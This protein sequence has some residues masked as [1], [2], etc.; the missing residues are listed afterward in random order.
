M[1]VY[2]EKIQGQPC[3]MCGAPRPEWHH[4][5]PRSKFSKRNKKLQEHKDNAIPLCHHCHQGHHT[6]HHL[7][8]RRGVL[9]KEE[10]AFMEAN[11]HPGWIDKWYPTE[12]IQ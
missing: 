5:L 3:R 4:L 10:I 1:T 7:R 9:K 8:V 12:E 2:E 6:T 11:I